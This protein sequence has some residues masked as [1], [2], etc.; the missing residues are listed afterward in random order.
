MFREEITYFAYFRYYP[1]LS[2]ELKHPAFRHPLIF[3]EN[4]SSL[5]LP[6]FAFYTYYHTS[7][8]FI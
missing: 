3:N 2:W 1:E 6:R 7:F 5:N 4:P 8:F